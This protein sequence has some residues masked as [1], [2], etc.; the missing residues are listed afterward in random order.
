MLPSS[1]PNAHQLVPRFIVTPHSPILGSQGSDTAS[2]K[3]KADGRADGSVE[4]QS[5]KKKTAK[6]TKASGLPGGKG[7][8]QKGTSLQ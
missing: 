4:P 8:R 6:T 3:R 5:K 2:K 1:I 7:S